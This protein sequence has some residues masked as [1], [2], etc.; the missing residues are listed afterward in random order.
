MWTVVSHFLL[1]FLGFLF[2]LVLEENFWGI[3][4]TGFYR[5]DAIPNQSSMTCATIGAWHYASLTS[6]RTVGS[7]LPP[8]LLA[9]S[10]QMWTGRWKNFGSRWSMASWGS[11][12]FIRQL[13]KQNLIG[14]S[15]R[16]NS[17]E[18]SKQ[19]ESTGLDN[20][21]KWRLLSHS[22]YCVIPD[23]VMPLPL[24]NQRCQSTKGKSE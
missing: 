13:H 4:G 23:K 19:R 14:V 21:G 15:Q 11:F 8:W 16:I 20:G 18:M 12:P 5:P 7:E 17:S 1:G 24:C 9:A 22:T 2:P 6:S 10:C 3:N